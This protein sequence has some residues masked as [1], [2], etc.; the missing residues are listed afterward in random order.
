MSVA[1]GKISSISATSGRQNL[2]ERLQPKPGQ[3][4]RQQGE[5]NGNRNAAHELSNQPVAPNSDERCT[6][7][8]ATASAKQTTGQPTLPAQR[9]RCEPGHD[10]LFKPQRRQRRAQTHARPNAPLHELICSGVA[11]K[12]CAATWKAMA[13]GLVN[14]QYGDK[15]QP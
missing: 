12:A 11:P 13:T 8:A 7:K 10:R 15:T 14:P 1:T 2:P 5:D 9:P 6:M 4:A 3:H